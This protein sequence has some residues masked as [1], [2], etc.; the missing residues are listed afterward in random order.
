MTAYAIALVTIKDPEK[1]QQ[2]SSIAG[3]SV[4]SHGGKVSAKGKV[5][6]LLTGDASWDLV[7]V[8][9]FPSMEQLDRWYESDEYQSVIAVRDQ[10]CEMT[11]LKV[12]APQG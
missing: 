5:A 1:L 4:I 7:A 12:Q 2:Y 8:M 11:I 3:P 9:E 10:A 6:G